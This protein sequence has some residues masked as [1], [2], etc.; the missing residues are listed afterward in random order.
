[1]KITQ[2]IPGSIFKGA[3][4]VATI[5]FNAYMPIATFRDA[6]E[7]GNSNIVAGAKAAGEFIGWQVAA[8]LMAGKMVYDIGKAVTEAGMIIG[9]QNIS[10]ANRQYKHNF[11]GNYVDGNMTGNMRKVGMG[12]INKSSQSLGNEAKTVYRRGDTY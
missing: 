10:N 7:S 3:F 4:K 5:G 6:K 2:G 1:M 11:G 8:P 9:K 12:N